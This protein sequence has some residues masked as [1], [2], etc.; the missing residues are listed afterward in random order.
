VVLKTSTHTLLVPVQW[1][2]A[3]LSHTPPCEVPVQP[4]VDG[5]KPFA[6]QAPLDPVHVSATSH[7]PAE[8]RHCVVFDWKTSTHTLLVPVQWSAASLSHAPPCEVPVQLV[9][10]DRKTSAGQAPLDPVHVSA[11]S[12][13]P[14]EARHWV[15][16]ELKTSTHTLL[17]PVQ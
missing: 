8:A 4:V 15:V 5:W 16:L 10:A 14:A 7:W 2:A 3:S 11:T 1:S 13:W 6:G 9:A 12:H 17:V